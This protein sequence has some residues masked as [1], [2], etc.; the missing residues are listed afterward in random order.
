VSQLPVVIEPTCGQRRD[1][2]VRLL[3]VAQVRG[4]E[5]LLFVECGDGWI[6]EEAWRRAL[7][8]FAYGLDTSR[9]HVTR[10]IALRGVPGK[11][12]FA[13]WDGIRLP[14]PALSFHRV[15]STFALE[16][17]AEPDAL[18]GEMYRVLQP[19]GELYVLERERAAARD[20]GGG[21]ASARLSAAL[22]R[23]G[24]A[25][26]NE[27]LRHTPAEGSEGAAGVIIR[28]RCPARPAA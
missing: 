28:A 20:A 25:E 2:D 12:E 4:L 15:F 7:K 27:L 6:A 26:S 3:D 8:G 13:T 18:V 14:C 16:R 19:S 1:W 21:C 22:H 23:A 17:C 10:A 11:V 24:F 9:S 5:R